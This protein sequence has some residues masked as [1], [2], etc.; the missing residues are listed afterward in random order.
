MARKT[1][2]KQPPDGKLSI[3]NFGV[4][5]QVD[6]ALT[7]NLIV[8]GGGNGAGKTSVL[9][10][11]HTCIVG[12]R[13]VE[14]KASPVRDGEQEGSVFLDLGDLEIMRRF[15]ARD[16]YEVVLKRNGKVETSKVQDRLDALVSKMTFDPSFLWDSKV[17][18]KT[19]VRMFL[20]AAGVDFSD[21][22]SKRAELYAQRTEIG[23]E[24]DRLK[25]ALD[26]YPLDFDA[27]DSPV[28]VSVLSEN[29]QEQM[30]A[31]AAKNKLQD[32][33]LMRDH[34]YERFKVELSAVRAEI[35]Q[36]QDRERKILEEGKAH[37]AI[38]K[39][40]TIELEAMPDYD[41]RTLRESIANADK[42]NE[43]YR[44][45]VQRAEFG[46]ALKAAED[47]Y[48]SRS[49]EI[50]DIDT[51][52]TLRLKAAKL[53]LEGLSA[54][55][56]G[57]WLNGYP[58]SRASGRD[59][60]TVALSIAFANCDPDFPL[61]CCDGG[62]QFDPEWLPHIE[63]MAEEAGIVVIL[64]RV[65]KDALC[66]VIMQDGQVL[67]EEK[68]AG[69]DPMGGLPDYPETVP[70]TDKA[71]SMDEGKETGSVSPTDE[72]DDA[73]STGVITGYDEEMESA[74]AE[75]EMTEEEL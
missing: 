15:N 6:L 3:T 62:E 55:E 51:Q 16:Q 67:S 33:I 34:Q 39:Q 58:I 28:D 1:A 10:A 35:K 66:T 17:D 18:E 44:Q 11:I 30:D 52:K 14:G 7:K 65:A 8:V 32:T 40:F 19:R 22:E 5:R 54:T 29:L 64:T 57:I 37:G 9:R 42:H 75:A 49:L 68:F 27:Q 24:R 73:M 48:T 71:F 23:R 4:L 38:T 43:S 36:L 60:L 72:E 63:A 61:V 31:N 53:P 2:T 26:K 69:M 74:Q 20:E 59:R 25:G 21:L 70:N 47:E 45:G 12:K 50:L 41:T 46:A 13:A 56:E